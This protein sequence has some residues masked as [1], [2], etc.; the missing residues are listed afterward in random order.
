[1]AAPTT[2]GSEDSESRKRKAEPD[3][4][5]EAKRAKRKLEEV[6]LILFSPYPIDRLHHDFVF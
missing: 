1:M 5:E 6:S 4:D 2:N 3:E